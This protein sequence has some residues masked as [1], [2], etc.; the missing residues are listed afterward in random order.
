MKKKILIFALTAVMVLLM[1]I[2]AFAQEEISVYLNDKQVSFPD[3]TPVISEGVLLIPLRSVFETMDI[4]VYWA[5][6]TSPVVCASDEVI[7]FS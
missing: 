3:R 5:G 7:S 1:N 2:G 6:D 4:D